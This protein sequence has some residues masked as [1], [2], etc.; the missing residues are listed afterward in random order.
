MHELLLA[1]A[2]SIG[3]E[4]RTG[5]NAIAFRQN[6]IVRKAGIIL[7]NGE[8]IEGDVVV[9]IGV[10]NFEREDIP[11]RNQCSSCP[12]CSNTPPNQGEANAVEKKFFS[13]ENSP[14]FDT[15]DHGD[16]ISRRHLFNK[17]DVIYS[18]TGV[19]CPHCRHLLLPPNSYHSSSDFS[20]RYI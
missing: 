10:G 5:L 7:D 9:C 14:S 19:W 8:R 12:F 6:E 20:P 15:W 1:H 18:R 17:E 3:V 11:V 4:V 2:L 13:S 16:D